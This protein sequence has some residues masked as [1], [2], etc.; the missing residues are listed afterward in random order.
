MYRIEKYLEQQTTEYTGSPLTF[1]TN[2]LELTASGDEVLS[3]EIGITAQMKEGMHCLFYSSHYR[4]QCLEREMPQTAQVLKYRFDSNGLDEGEEIRGEFSIVSPAGEYRIPYVV[5]V[6]KACQNDRFGSIRNL[7]HF[8]NLA[9]EDFQEAVRLFYMPRFKSLL[10]GHDRQYLGLYK[11]LSAASGNA[12]NVDAFLTAI[13]KKKEA[14]YHV[15]EEKLILQD[16]D[17]KQQETVILER[18]GWG[19]VHI[20]VEACGGFLEPQKEVLTQ[21]DFVGNECA[22]SFVVNPEKLGP[23][24]HTGRLVF[25]F[26]TKE[27]SC[28]I[29]VRT[30][31][32]EEKRAWER[33]ESKRMTAQLMHLY[34]DYVTGSQDSSTCL[35]KA[36]KLIERMNAQYGRNVQARLY[37]AHVLLEQ[38]REN[39]AGWVLSHVE[40]MLEQE[41]EK[42]S[43]SVYAYYLYLTARLQQ[44]RHR[45]ALRQLQDMTLQ[46]RGGAQAVCFYFRLL[47][48]SEEGEVKRFAVYEEAFYKGTASPLLLREAWRILEESMA[49]LTKL[50]K[51]EIALLRFA[52]RYGLYTENAAMQVNYLVKRKKDMDKPLYEMLV[53]SYRIFPQDETI[54]AVCALMIR[55]GLTGRDSFRWYALAV[56]KELRI[57]SLYEYYMLSADTTQDQLPPKIVLMYFAYACDLPDHRKAYLYRLILSHRHEIAQIFAQYEPQIKEFGRKQ[58][59]KDIISENHAVIY[60]YLLRDD[61]SMEGAAA[62]L[63]QIAFTHCIQVKDSAMTNVVVIHDRLAGEQICPIEKGR[64]YVACYTDNYTILL[65]DKYGN[66][67]C[68][69]NLWVDEKLMMTDRIA[70]FLQQRKEQ[71]V[72]FMLYRTY[73]M[74][75]EDFSDEESWEMYEK[76]AL[77]EQ[78]DHDWRIKLL[79]RLLALYYEK[80]MMQDMLRILSAYP[81]EAADQRQRGH[82]IRCYAACGQDDKAFQLLYEYGFEGVS[83]IALTRLVNRNLPA[84]DRCDVRLSHLCYYCFKQGKYTDD[85]LACLVMYF[86][87]DI[88]QMRDVWKVAADFGVEAAAL[89]ERILLV[90]LFGNG[91]ISQLEQVFAYYVEHAGRESIIRRYVQ[92]HAYA[93]FVWQQEPQKAVFRQLERYLSDGISMDEISRLSYLHYMAQDWPACSQEQQPLIAKLVEEFVF[94]RQYVPFFAAFLPFIPWLSLFTQHTYIEYRTRPGTMVFLHYVPEDGEAYRTRRMTEIG[95]GYYCESF[96][97]LFSEKLRYYFVEQEDGRENLTESCV[98][99]KSDMAGN[100]SG[101]RFGLL[102]DIMLSSCMSDEKTENTLSREYLYESYLHELLGGCMKWKL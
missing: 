85:M 79:D 76:L 101:G 30:G 43:D 15:K 96:L 23:G 56:E 26:G 28:D 52:M 54:Q 80:D 16:V 92:R 33:L 86:E 40:N 50:G 10:T 47:P 89:A 9:Q 61:E 67:Y 42:I 22:V 11:G 97:L 62:H 66:R 6:E 75:E 88:K 37:Q 19:H 84:A 27:T 8:A 20:R 38:E 98:V 13:H 24:F 55:I 46:G 73:L 2:R 60:Q 91:Y 95:G 51:F 70:L 78:V 14:T 7:F 90:H 53:M 81:V 94:D 12:A 18:T 100:D 49:Y 21:E 25:H 4:M 72:G 41:R 57:T 45:E 83:P 34:M 99:E 44:E 93:Y 39:E 59:E 5:R 65:E 64:A 63:M 35:Y 48:R 32:Q 77:S 102:N 74:G 1:S 58:L 17:A 71:S 29:L 87:G 82:I 3:G 31:K 69:D 68:D 36:E